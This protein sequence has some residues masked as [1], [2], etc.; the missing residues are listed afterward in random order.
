MIVAAAVA[1]SVQSGAVLRADDAAQRVRPLSTIKLYVAAVWWD[2]GLPGSLDDMLVDGLD[3]PGRERAIELRK[4]FGGAAVL[5]D[6]RKLGLEGLTLAPDADDATWGE[7][8][9]IGEAQVTV[10][11]EQ[12][13]QFLRTIARSKS[14]TARK[15]RAAMIA[16]V[17]R[18]T[19]RR[20]PPIG[21]GWQLG[22][23]TGTAANHDGLF[24]GLAFENGAPRYAIAVYLPGEGPGGGKPAAKAVEI[25]RGL[26][27][28]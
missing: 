16:C 11:L 27:G 17:S 19:A 28:R 8:L 18:G 26:V 14:E 1:L 12:V 22:G 15:L 21:R 23:K 4:R 2:R 13:A 9:S 10:T 25:A 20:A 24:A 7:V 5:A 3:A 6:L